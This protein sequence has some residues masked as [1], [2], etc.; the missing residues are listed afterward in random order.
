MHSSGRLAHIPALSQLQG[1]FQPRASRPSGR[2]RV[3][4]PGPEA[5]APAECGDGAGKTSEGTFK[6]YAHTWHV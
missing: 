3:L 6:E 4:T 5:G 1:S 2:I